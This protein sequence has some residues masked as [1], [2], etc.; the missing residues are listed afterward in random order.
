MTLQFELD[1]NQKLPPSAQL[2]MKQ[3]DDNADGRWKRWVDGA[4]Q[5]V[6]RTHQEFTVDDVLSELEKM[7]NPPD[8]HNLGALGPRMR[9]VAKV[10][11]YMEPSDRVQRSK[12]KIKKGNLHR[13]WKSRIYQEAA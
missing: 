1:W 10:L 5:A 4:I 8:T 2:G 3:A 11:G 12:R 6:A 9:E 7:P 13:V